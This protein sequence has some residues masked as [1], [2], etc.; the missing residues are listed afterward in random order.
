MVGTAWWQECEALGHIA[1][2]AKKHEEM[3]ACPQLTSFFLHS[4]GG[5]GEMNFEDASPQKVAQHQGPY[6]A[7]MNPPG[8]TEE[9]SEISRPRSAAGGGPP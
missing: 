5:Q 8:C 9:G 3:N 1:S 6:W 2:A 7:T 4:L